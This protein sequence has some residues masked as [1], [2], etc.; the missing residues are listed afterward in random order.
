M[1]RY[2]ERTLRGNGKWV[3][4]SGKSGRYVAAQGWQGDIK[5]I[6][7]L[8]YPTRDGALICAEHWINE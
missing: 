3:K 1:A 2:Y 6:R 4:V 5:A 8:T 7:T